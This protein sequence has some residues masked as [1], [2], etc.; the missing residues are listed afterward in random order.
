LFTLVG[1]AGEEDVDA[2]DLADERPSPKDN[3]SNAGKLK[4][5][6]AP[7]GGFCANRRRWSPPKQVLEPKRSAALRD[8]FV[9]ELVRLTSPEEATDWA[10]RA[11]GAKNTLRGADAAA[12][13]A[14][15]ASRMAELAS[16][17]SVDAP[18]SSSPAA[19][20]D[21]AA[22][23]ETAEPPGRIALLAALRA[24]VELGNG[25]G[26]AGNNEVSGEVRRR[27]DKPRS[28]RRAPTALAVP[29]GVDVQPVATAAPVDERGK[30]VIPWHIDKS[31]LALSEPRRY[32]DRDHLEFVAS[33]PCLVCGR[34]P[35][36]P[37]HLRFMQPRAL[38]RRVSDEFT[39]PLCRTHHRALHRRGDEVAWWQSANLDPATVA[40]RFWQHTRLGQALASSEKP[41]LAV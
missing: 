41:N 20:L 7:L 27:S 38:G 8:Q 12:V 1:I 37:H 5:K 4:T 15:F 21:P 39:V 3:G 6:D 24:S 25:S 33:Q 40:Q 14:P 36:D 23:A 17:G 31:V 35:S 10:Q 16:L 32:R 28:H 29:I 26:A 18:L 9:A 22:P 2:P 30:D 19:S 34:K 13:E 11:L